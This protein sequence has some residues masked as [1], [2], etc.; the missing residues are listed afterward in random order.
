MSSTELLPAASA[1]RENGAGHGFH[2]AGEKHKSALEC[3]CMVAQHHAITVTV[4]EIVR[5]NALTDPAVDYDHLVHCAR[6]IGLKAKL[7]RLDWAGLTQLRK[8]LPAIVRLK[9]G[10][11]LVLARVSDEGQSVR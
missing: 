10:A 9:T 2:D 4:A 5:D 1:A 6:Q 11:S 7:V 8:A 3:L